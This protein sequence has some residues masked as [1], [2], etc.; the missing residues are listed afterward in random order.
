MKGPGFTV[1]VLA[2][3]ALGTRHYRDL[4]CG[5]LWLMAPLA[6][7]KPRPALSSLRECRKH[8]SGNANYSVQTP[9]FWIGALAKPFFRAR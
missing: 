6:V 1:V 4:H 9:E 3:L 5:Q 7:S 2:V 8:S